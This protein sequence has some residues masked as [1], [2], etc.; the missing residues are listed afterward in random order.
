MFAHGAMRAREGQRT[1][2]S[3]LPPSVKPGVVT[4]KALIDLLSY[5]KEKKF[6]IPAVNCVSSSSINQVRL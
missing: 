5:A 1:I 6:A 3:N 4:G 2:F